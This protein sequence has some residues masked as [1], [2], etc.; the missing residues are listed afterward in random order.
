MRKCLLSLAILLSLFLI[1][2]IL[3]QNASA[4]KEELEEIRKAIKEAGAKWKADETSVSRL[5]PQER[6]K[7][8]GTILDEVPPGQANAKPDKPGKPKPPPPPT[9]H[10]GLPDYYDWRDP[11]PEANRLGLDVVT[12]IKNQGSCGSCWAFG[13]IAALESAW[14]ISNP[15]LNS[16]DLSEQDLVSCCVNCWGDPNDPEGGC[17]GG[18]MDRTYNY[19]CG[20]GAIYESCFGYVAD[21][22]ECIDT[23]CSR[24][25]ISGWTPVE[26][27]LWALQEAIFEQP[28]PAAF[29]VFRD[30]Y[31]YTEGVYSH[32]ERGKPKPP[33]GGHAISIIGW[34]NSNA[35]LHVKNSW[36]TGWGEAGFFRVAY[37]EIYNSVQFGRAAANYGDGGTVLAPPRVEFTTATMWG[38]I[39]M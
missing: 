33:I 35:C 20:P 29:S 9:P 16:V 24:I 28:I 12:P 26:H 27:D 32:V 1:L 8:V 36:G 23:G 7:L 4:D 6:R 21:N 31:Y 2:G 30:F 34:D 14:L 10:P 3:A 25:S 15:K 37:T 38:K 18:Y 39:K 5:S 22:V 13:A 17:G 19:L 11:D